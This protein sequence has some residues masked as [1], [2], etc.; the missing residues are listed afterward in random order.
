MGEGPTAT[1]CLRSARMTATN[2]ATFFR[3]PGLQSVMRPPQMPSHTASAEIPS[4]SA[5]ATICATDYVRCACQTRAWANENRGHT[6]LLPELARRC[7]DRA[8]ECGQVRRIVDKLQVR[9]QVLDLRAVSI[10]RVRVSEERRAHLDALKEPF[11]LEH[12][13]RDARNLQRGFN[14]P[15]ERVRPH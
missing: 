4:A 9:E 2:G 11:A 14:I 3:T 5:R 13:V 15:R 8:H 12:P 1:A 10:A 7:V 6:Y